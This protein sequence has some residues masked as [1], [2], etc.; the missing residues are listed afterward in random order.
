MRINRE[1]YR[2]IL[3]TALVVAVL[4]AAGWLLFPLWLAVVLSVILGVLLVLTCWFF[5]EPQRP[6]LA[7]DSLIYSPADGKVVVV[8][9]TLE[10]E[11]FGD[12]RIQVSVFMS[13]T[14]VHVNWFPI[15]G[16][17][18]YYKYHPG[19]FLVAWHPKS[20]EENER[21]ITVVGGEGREVLFRQV[22]GLVARRIVSYAVKDKEVTQ[23][24]KCGFIKFGSR[25]DLL[26]PPDC[27]ILV[28]EGQK[29]RGSQTAVARFR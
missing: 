20:S 27:E 7:D 25:I 3:V 1:G 13:V 23:N 6:L 17:V 24:E 15:G 9:R 29:V 4:G 14:N 22:A 19:R 26:L 10:K 16:R 2:I 11:Y 18:L 21:T 12:E 28:G 5:R 8:E